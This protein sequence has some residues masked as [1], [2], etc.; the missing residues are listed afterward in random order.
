MSAYQV[1]PT[2]IDLIVSKAIELRLYTNRC[3]YVTEANASIYANLLWNENA[4]SIAYRYAEPISTI[5]PYEFTLY[6]NVRPRA[7]TGCLNCYAYQACEHPEWPTSDAHDFCAR[8][9]RR[10]LNS[11]LTDVPWGVEGD[12]IPLGHADKALLRLSSLIPRQ[13]KV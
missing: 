12:P 5:E 2:T 3:E 11:I 13:R 4:K 9:T 6:D 1:D 8:L 10:L 7:A